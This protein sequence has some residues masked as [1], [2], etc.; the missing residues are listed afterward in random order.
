MLIIQPAPINSNR[1]KAIS[2]I[3]FLDID[4]IKCGRPIRR[5]QTNTV[6][7]RLAELLY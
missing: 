7:F 6:L 1:T 5:E 2:G 4:I 3:N